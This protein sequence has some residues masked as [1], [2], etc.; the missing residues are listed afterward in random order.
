MKSTDVAAA[1]L[2]LFCRALQTGL[3][4]AAAANPELGPV[5][6]TSIALVVS[7]GG[8]DTGF[9]LCTAHVAGESP[10]SSYVHLPDLGEPVRIYEHFLSDVRDWI[11]ESRF[12]W[13]LKLE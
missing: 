6:V 10:V 11:V 7:S 3:D 5:R 1:A 8:D 9:Y 4:E 13:G 2:P 12:G